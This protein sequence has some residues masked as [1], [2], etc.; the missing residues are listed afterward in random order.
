M[1]AVQIIRQ[2]PPIH[3]CIVM[4]SAQITIY[5]DPFAK[6]TMML[7]NVALQTCWQCPFSPSA[8]HIDKN[9]K[10]KHLKQQVYWVA[11]QA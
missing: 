9:H 6:E 7:F 2:T 3:T 11:I 8:D 1:D 10:E 4:D 5:H